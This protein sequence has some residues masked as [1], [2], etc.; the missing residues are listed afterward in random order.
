MWSGALKHT[1][2]ELL[3]KVWF[4]R[5]LEAVVSGTVCRVSEPPAACR[6]AQT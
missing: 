3:G 5:R 1:Q 6:G 2:R 4:G